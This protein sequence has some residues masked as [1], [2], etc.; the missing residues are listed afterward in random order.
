V[1]GPVGGL[2]RYVS[3]SVFACATVEEENGNA[4]RGNCTIGPR[5]WVMV[6]DMES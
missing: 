2:K 4:V 5:L 1:N 3:R 6:G